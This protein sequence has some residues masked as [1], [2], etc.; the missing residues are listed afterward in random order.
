[1]GSWGRNSCHGV[2][3]GSSSYPPTA[4]GKAW[5]RRARLEQVMVR[6]TQRKEPLT[7]LRPL[8]DDEMYQVL[9]ILVLARVANDGSL[10]SPR[11]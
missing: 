7:T 10:K 9:V 1:M 4:D 5:V 3:Y 8:H 2:L 11:L 6:A